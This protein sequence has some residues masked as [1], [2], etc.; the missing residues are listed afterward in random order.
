M[1][2]DKLHTRVFGRPRRK[3]AGAANRERAGAHGVALSRDGAYAFISN[4]V[5]NTLTVIDV[6]R[7]RALR[8]W[9]AGKAPNGFVAF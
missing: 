4:T 3:G 5:A 9:S 7:A 1:L 8:S 6:E 2:L